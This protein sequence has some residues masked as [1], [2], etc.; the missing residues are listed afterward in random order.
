MNDKPSNE[1]ILRPEITAADLSAYDCRNAALH[2]VSHAVVANRWTEQLTVRIFPNDTGSTA[3]RSVVG[4]MS[5]R[6]FR[7]RLGMSAVGWAGFLGEFIRDNPSGDLRE[8]LE[9][10]ELDPEVMSE[11]DLREIEQVGG[12]ERRKAAK[13][14]FEIIKEDWSQVTKVEKQLCAEYY[15]KQYALARWNRATGWL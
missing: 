1:I 4:Q 9:E 3:E 11:S 12:R 10:Y 2:E 8:A 13:I 6:P 5:F 7:S 14:A 15:L